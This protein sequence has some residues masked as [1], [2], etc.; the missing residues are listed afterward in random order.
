MVP[1]RK[2]HWAH[3]SRGS[4]AGARIAPWLLLS[5][6]GIAPLA[7]AHPGPAIEVAALDALR[8]ERSQDPALLVKRAAVL[9]RA[10]QLDRALEDLAEAARLAPSDSAVARERGLTRAAKGLHALAEADLSAALQAAPDDVEALFARGK[11]HE[12][13]DKR[14]AAR[15]DYDAALKRRRTPETCLARGHI[16][17]I[18]GKLGEAA[19][20]YRAGLRDLGGAVTLR[21]ALV[22]VERARGLLAAALA[23][24][25]EAM[26]RPGLHTDWLLIRADIHEQAGRALAARRDREAALAEIDTALAQKATALRQVTRARALRA[27]GRTEEARALLETVAAASPRLADAQALLKDMRDRAAK[28]RP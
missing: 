10:G 12:A 28:G 4:L 22:R 11:V 23:L 18:S 16:D 21:L 17:E 2:F 27:L 5:I 13:L 6:A 9:R 24:V 8:K 3:S 15:S 26:A 7:H 1:T 14:A 20:V 19:A 25:N